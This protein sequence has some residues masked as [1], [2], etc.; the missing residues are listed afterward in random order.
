MS[1]FKNVGL[2]SQLQYI[3]TK[4]RWILNLNIE[5]YPIKLLEENFREYFGNLIAGRIVLLKT[6]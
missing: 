4:L 6:Q 2:D 5:P 3:R 1:I